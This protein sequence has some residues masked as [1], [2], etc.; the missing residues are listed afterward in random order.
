MN[1]IHN[2]LPIIGITMGDPAGNGPELS[3]KA[4]QHAD[5]YARCRPII[6]GDATALEQAKSFISNPNLAI[7]R[8]KTVEDALFLPGTVDVLHLDLIADISKMSIGK[9]SAEAGMAA[10]LSV[11]K[12]IE[13]A[14]EDVL[15]ATVTN[16][17][18]KE[19]MNL[20][21]EPEGM[22]FA[23]HTEIYAHYTG[24][25]NYAMMLTHH[26]LRVIHVS[27][28]CSLREACDRVKKARVLDVI[29]TA[30]D[31]CR[32]LGIDQPRIAVAGLNPHAGENGLFGTE[33]IDEI[34]PAIEAA[35]AEGINAIG[36]EPADSL[37]SKA[38]GGWYDIVVVMYHDQ[39]HIPL[40]TVGFVY[41]REAKHWKSVE[42]V[43][44]TLGLPIIRTSVDHGTGF[45]QAGKGTSSELS[46]INA[47]DYAI[48]MANHRS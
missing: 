7:H 11:K 46:L 40:K 6:I 39:G 35:R 2:K 31:A 23:G 22:H 12:T 19:A 18:N 30:Y 38:L 45:D 25:K 26:D 15:D 3:L 14:M 8:C 37:F 10:F 29:H 21:L 17:L 24:T 41:D 47:I 28:H 36:P 9:I 4:L 42:G 33:E 34:N 48:T 43:N 20:A 1:Q 27:T 13:L 32:K 5:L 16:A 44:V